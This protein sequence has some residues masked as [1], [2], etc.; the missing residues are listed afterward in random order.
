[1]DWLDGGE[2]LLTAQRE[3]DKPRQSLKN[4]TAG[5]REREDENRTR[6]AGNRDE[7]EGVAASTLNLYR[8]GAVGFIDW[9]DHSFA[10]MI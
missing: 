9:L 1:M 6:E 2:D 5:V 4:N 3:R 10:T 7:V 8:N